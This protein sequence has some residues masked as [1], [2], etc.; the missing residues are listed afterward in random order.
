[1]SDFITVLQCMP[2][3]REGGNLVSRIHQVSGR[4]FSRILKD[5]NIDELNPAQ[6]RIL[7][8]LWKED[9]LSQTELAFRTKLDKS[10]LALM[11]DRLERDGQIERIRADGDARRKFIRAT[12]EN[13]K[14]H[15]EYE[16]ASL[17]MIGLFYDGLTE[18]E[19]DRFEK[20]ASESPVESRKG[21]NRT[22]IASYIAAKYS[23]MR[24]SPGVNSGWKVSPSKFSKRTI[25]G[26]P[27]PDALGAHARTVTPSSTEII[28]GARINVAGQGLP[29]N[30]IS[31]TNDSVCLPYAFRSTVTEACRA[32][33]RVR[34]YRG[35]RA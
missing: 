12:A 13:R 18:T 25:T 11:L 22:E 6:G 32:R 31:C 24:V 3:M 16:K 7:Y 14:L 10:T 15:G 23:C 4:V 17:E 19:I 21:M 28:L 8:E 5:H 1:M 9:S 33:R 30:S 20:N 29:S 26:S 34:R 27:L 2:L 35:A